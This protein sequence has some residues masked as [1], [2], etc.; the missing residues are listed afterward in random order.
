[1][2]TVHNN[3]SHCSNWIC[4]LYIITLWAHNYVERCILGYIKFLLAKGYL[5]KKGCEPLLQ[6]II[7]TLTNSVLMM[8]HLVSKHVACPFIIFI[9]N[10]NF[11]LNILHNIVIVCLQ[12]QCIQ[13]LKYYN[14]IGLWK[15][16]GR[17]KGQKIKKN[18]YCC[19][20]TFS[21][22]GVAFSTSKQFIKTGCCLKKVDSIFDEYIY[23]GRGLH[24]ATD[25]EAVSSGN[26]LY[27]SWKQTNGPLPNSIVLSFGAEVTSDEM[28]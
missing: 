7:W 23:A 11:I 13:I 24:G 21:R 18:R 1:M 14:H 10:S 16:I 3:T 8:T 19:L 22:R 12:R 25:I 27:N 5:K 6:C 17:N 20:R 26:R 15:K 28:H 9:F 4:T 2:N